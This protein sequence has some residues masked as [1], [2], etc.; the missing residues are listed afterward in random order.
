M[1]V[2]ESYQMM[3]LRAT[4]KDIQ[5]LAFMQDYALILCTILALPVRSLSLEFEFARDR[6]VQQVS[7]T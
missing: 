7:R 6:H 4:G 2:R 3:S 1:P 5:V